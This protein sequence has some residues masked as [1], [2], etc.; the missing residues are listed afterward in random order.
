MNHM[1]SWWKDKPPCLKDTIPTSNESTNKEQ[2]SSQT[3]TNT[4]FYAGLMEKPFF[5]P[6][7]SQIKKTIMCATCVCSPRMHLSVSVPRFMKYFISP[8]VSGVKMCHFTS[9][10]P[11]TCKHTPAHSKTTC[12]HTSTDTHTLDLEGVC[13][14]TQQQEVAAWIQEVG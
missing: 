2:L 11:F 1:D 3:S 5:F 4:S 13:A 6:E 9:C 8:F 14:A 12:L 10:Y 7:S